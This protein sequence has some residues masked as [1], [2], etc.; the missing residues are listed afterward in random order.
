MFDNTNIRPGRS[1]AVANVRQ[2]ANAIRTWLYFKLRAPWVVTKGMVRIPWSVELWSPNKD[3]SFGKNIQ[4][5]KNGIIN[6][7]IS[8]GDN[9]LIARNVSFVGRDDHTYNVIGKTIWASPRGDSYK[10]IVE[11]DVWFGHGV[12][13]V[14]GVTVGRGSIIAAGAVLVK[15]VPK[16]TIVGGVPARALGKRFEDDEVIQHE[17]ILGY[18]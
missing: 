1:I 8:F 3:I 9:V 2:V 6:C 18:I 16:Y 11:D 13:V 17:K 5:G 14:A 7:D 12:I 15:D 10:T 4:F